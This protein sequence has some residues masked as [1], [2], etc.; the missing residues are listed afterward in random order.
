MKFVDFVK[1]QA[2]SG[3]GGNGCSAY[4]REKFVPFGGPAGGDG[5]KGGDV[6][7]RG[8]TNLNTLLH[9]GYN[10]LQKAEHGQDGM[11]SDRHG[12]KGKDCVIEVPLGTVVK[13]ADTDE[14]LLEVI[15]AE[16]YLLLPGGR[17]GRGNA[18]FKTSTNRAPEFCEE[19]KPGARR[20]L[21]LE[22]KLMADVGLVGFPNAGKSTLISAISKAKPK[23]ADYPFTTLIPNLG[24]VKAGDYET[25]V[26][27]D[28]PGIIQGAHS[29]VGLG[30]RFLR[31]IERTAVL[32]LLLD[33][34]GFSQ[35]P[36]AE[37]YRILLEELEL[38]KPEL[39]QKQRL[40]V[41]NKLDAVSDR[42]EIE[43]LMQ[44]LNE[45]DETVLEISAATGQGLD[46]LIQAMFQH[47]Q[48][49]RQNQLE[50]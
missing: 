5:G 45:L 19:G 28:I 27:A 43:E 35:N 10:P 2:H 20:S 16:E 46:K 18:R 6:L 31:H 3:N 32:V 42:T 39:V 41:L 11:G 13:D 44:V 7:V 12:H 49:S 24:V 15:K 21:M 29:G 40:V 14:I 1:I 38:F 48:V 25:F 47:V 9:L 17:G 8:N 23:I 4:R 22:L 30:D 36:P 37:E 26:V 33:V 34:S 50:S